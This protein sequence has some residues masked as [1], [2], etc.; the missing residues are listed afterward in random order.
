M[1]F[2]LT[3]EQELMRNMVRDFAKNELAPKAA[4]WDENAEF[5]RENLNKMA[6]LDLMGMPISEEAGGAGTTALS[7]VMA[8]EEIAR[9][10]PTTAVI[11][12]VHTSVGTM[13]IYLFGNEAQKTKYLKKLATGEFLGAFALTEPTAGSDATKVKCTAELIG[14]H[15]VVNGTKIFITNGGEAD[16]Y[17]VFV[18]TDKSKGYNGI[19]CLLVDKDTPGFRIGTIE[20]KMGLN[21]SKTAEL[22][23]ENALVPKENL[24]HKAGE[25]FKV[26]MALLDYG[27]IGIG[28]QGVG[29]A[30]GA[31]DHALEYV[32]QRE[33]FG[34][35]IANFQAIQFKLADIATEIEAARMLVYQAASLKDAGIPYGKQAS[36]AKLYATDVAM[37][38]TTECIQLLGG[39][40][41]TRE[42]PVERYF[43]DA[44]VTQ[45]Y[46]GTNQVQ[47][48][49]IAK[50]I[51]K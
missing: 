21:G 41:Y 22:I 9:A 48:V 30:Q 17:T 29:I 2:K 50:H 20:K 47:R 32:K 39:Y 37:D 31:F 44:K 1:D 33:Q 38:V 27:R 40:G 28:A 42:Y 15:Y 6:K 45:I 34:S 43:R 25:G 13:P 51:L 14:D 36:M 26:A 4:Y 24:L 3:E 23:F 12:A 8:I 35:P 5:P 11:V 18:V 46:E 19:S 7:Y 49:V 10:C 16:V